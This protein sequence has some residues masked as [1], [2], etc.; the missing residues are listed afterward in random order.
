MLLTIG[1]TAYFQ[2]TSSNTTAIFCLI[3]DFYNPKYIEIRIIIFNIQFFFLIFDANHRRERFT[4][5]S[6]NVN[7]FHSHEMRPHEQMLQLQVKKP[8]VLTASKLC[9]SVR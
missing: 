7:R 8:M 4:N 1:T 9:S 3:V 2:W 6:V 5:Q